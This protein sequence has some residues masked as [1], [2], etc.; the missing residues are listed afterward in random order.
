LLVDYR[1]LVTYPPARWSPPIHPGPPDPNRLALDLNLTRFPNDRSPSARRKPFA[2]VT[3][4]WG[5]SAFTPPPLKDSVTQYPCSADFE[6][7]LGPLWAGSY[8]LSCSVHRKDFDPVPGRLSL[9]EELPRKGGNQGEFVVGPNLQAKRAQNGLPINVTNLTRAIENPNMTA[10]ET[11]LGMIPFTLDHTGYPVVRLRAQQGKELS[12][13]EVAPV[14][15]SILPQFEEYVRSNPV[16]EQI[17]SPVYRLDVQRSEMIGTLDLPV[18][19]TADKL[20][21]LCKSSGESAVKAPDDEF[22]ERRLE[23]TL[24][25]AIETLSMDPDHSPAYAWA[26]LLNQRLGRTSLA[27]DF[28]LTLFLRMRLAER[29]LLHPE[30]DP[31]GVNRRRLRQA[32][33]GRLN[34]EFWS[35]F[36]RT[37]DALQLRGRVDLSFPQLMRLAPG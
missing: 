20:F 6:I 7:P 21:A 4:E 36:H 23:Q 29:I 17:F 14:I 18:Q 31:S 8:F 3:L 34:T 9:G 24:A 30:L 19:Q 13:A 15:P 25:T 12:V 5:G 11:P 37:S 1:I 22:L 10:I 33:T 16:G 27:F 35:L 32:T 26:A 28:F 2:R